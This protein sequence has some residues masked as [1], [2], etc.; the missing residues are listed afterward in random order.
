M[1]DSTSTFAKLLS[2]F[3]GWSPGPKGG[4]ARLGSSG[5]PFASSCK[6]SGKKVR[7]PESCGESRID[8]PL[9]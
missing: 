7:I 6:S 3:G 8:L 9:N 1:R 4:A 5:Q 2:A